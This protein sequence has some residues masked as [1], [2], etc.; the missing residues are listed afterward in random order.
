MATVIQH[1]ATGDGTVD[2]DV[3]GGEVCPTESD[4]VASGIRFL[5]K[6]NL[7]RTPKF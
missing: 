5:S 6:K 4:V 7:Q 2:A 1:K 3:G